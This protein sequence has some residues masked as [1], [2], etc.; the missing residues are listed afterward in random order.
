MIWNLNP[1]FWSV[2]KLL[3]VKHPF[4]NVSSVKMCEILFGL[5][6]KSRWLLFWGPVHANHS[7]YPILYF[8]IK[9]AQLW[10]CTGMKWNFEYKVWRQIS[11]SCNAPRLPPCHIPGRQKCNILANATCMHGLHW[12]DDARFISLKTAVVSPD[13]NWVLPSAGLWKYFS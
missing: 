10:T 8:L 2:K 4:M 13:G 12:Q 9:L 3:C 7:F 11:S 6:E 1:T 5:C